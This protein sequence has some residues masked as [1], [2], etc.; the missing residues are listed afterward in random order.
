MK[1]FSAQLIP[2]VIAIVLISCE[3]EQK[4]NPVDYG[5]AKGV[6]IVN[7]GSYNANNGSI[8]FLDTD[9]NKII[10]NLFEAANNRPVGDILQSFAVVNDSLGFAVVNNSAKIEIV[11][12]SD[13]SVIT[14]P[15]TITYPRYFIQA[16]P[17]KG[18]VS[19]GS[20]QG[21]LYIIDLN[22]FE[23][24]DSI[25]VGGGPENMILYNNKVYV[26]NSGGWGSD[27]TISVVSILNDEVTDTFHTADCPVDLVSDINDNLWV[28][29]K[30]YTNYT[31]IETEAFIQEIDVETGN[32][33]WQSKVGMA[34]DYSFTPAKCAASPD[35]SKIYY[36]RPDGIYQI[37]AGNPSI[38][39]EPIIPG[40]FYGLDVNPVDGNI[41]VF[42]SSFSG[43]GNMKIFNPSG[44][45]LS[46]AMV[47][48]GPNG[49]VFNM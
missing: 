40:N 16:D 37:D 26:A 27:S 28:Y 1:L 11:R 15:I 36:I 49:A 19:A 39:A 5:Y 12:L 9:S 43:N 29:C 21:Y 10:N 47:G 23:M 4:I 30:G 25:K 2:V 31:D 44:T 22:N 20:F 3:N 6:Y 46:E 32:I 33:I 24:T 45:K 35:R 38:A 13:F 48:I 8:S 18:Y 7:E 14:D 34:L 42:E 17:S 41:Y